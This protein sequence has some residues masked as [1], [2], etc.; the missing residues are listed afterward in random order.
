[1]HTDEPKSEPASG[2]QSNLVPV[3][4]PAWGGTVYVKFTD[5][6]K[7]SLERGVARLGREAAIKQAAAGQRL[8]TDATFR[9]HT[10]HLA[11][12]MVV[13]CTCDAAGVKMFKP[14]DEAML[15]ARFPARALLPLA[16]VINQLFVA[17][18]ARA[19][20]SH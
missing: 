8:D 9:A 11:R 3:P 4:M 16:T 7:A 2:S 12:L 6:E 15:A 17:S 18:Q 5:S 14:G 19:P 20:K 1:M 13:I 10:P